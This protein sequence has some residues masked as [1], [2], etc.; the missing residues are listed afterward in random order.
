MIATES[1]A[2]RSI[3]GRFVA[4]LLAEPDATWLARL[5]HEHAQAQVREAAAALDIDQRLVADVLDSASVERVRDM[6][7][8][9]LGHTARSEC[10]P[11]ELE[12]A[13]RDVFQQAH[14]LADIAAFYRAFGL[15]VNE[16]SERQDHFIPQWEFLSLCA[17]KEANAEELI[18]LSVIGASPEPRPS[19][20]GARPEGR[21]SEGGGQDS[22]EVVRVT[23]IC[24][25]AQ[26][27]FLK[28]HAARWMPSFFARLKKADPDGF[29]GHTALLTEALLNA[30]C[31]DFGV[32]L[33]S[34]WLEL[35]PEDEEDLRMECGPGAG[36]G[37]VALGPTLAA[38]LE[39]DG[40]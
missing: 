36:P 20:R 13:R 27:A 17:W 9:I 11:Y 22:A 33:G 21:G 28:D 34:D 6:R 26:R 16:R 10:P 30:W 19:G 1:A 38:A 14:A 12:Y 18:T 8:A 25:D 2:A 29:Y 37:Q 24:R 32:A 39:G 40:A 35:R 7:G 15:E 31:R 3:L 5:Q 23:E 4:E